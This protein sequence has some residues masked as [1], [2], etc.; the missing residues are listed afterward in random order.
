M[1]KPS[2]K[3]EDR[4]FGMPA[5][6]PA[7]TLSSHVSQATDLFSVR[8]EGAETVYACEGPPANP[9]LLFVHGWAASHKF[10]R[11]T[12]PALSPRY[13]C[14]A[15][16]LL[17]FALSEKPDRDYSMES[18]ARW[19]GTFLDMLEIE[20]LPIVA[21]SMGGMIA[22]LFALEH[23]ERVERLVL[24]NPVIQGPTA[25]PWRSRILTLPVIRR[26]AWCLLTNSASKSIPTTVSPWNSRILS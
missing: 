25:F 4:V 15:P 23:P 2:G 26:I 1:E 7:Q 13:R 6:W 14:L 12:V 19:L 18:Y 9:P 17:G 22:L 5:A 10:W 21:H 16:D 8:T 24:V 11:R 20:R 3:I